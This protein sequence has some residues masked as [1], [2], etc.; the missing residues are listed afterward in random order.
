[1]KK[2]IQKQSSRYWR[3]PL[4]TLCTTDAHAQDNTITG[5]NYAMYFL[6]FPNNNLIWMMQD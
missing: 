5:K 2:T 1:M 3:I 6:S 4:I